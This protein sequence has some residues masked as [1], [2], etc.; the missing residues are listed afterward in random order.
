MAIILPE[1]TK[2]RFNTT[3]SKPISIVDTSNEA[4]PFATLTGDIAVKTG[5][6][7]IVNQHN[8]GLL[9]EV[10][11]VAGQLTDD[12]KLRLLGHDTADTYYC[13]PGEG[14]GSLCIASDWVNLDQVNEI[15]ASGG[16]PKFYNYTHLDDPTGRER[17]I[18]TGTSP[19][20]LTFKPHYDPNL[21][22]Y[23]AI[24]MVQF[25]RQAVVLQLKYPDRAVIYHY[26][27]L[28]MEGSPTMAIG[29]GMQV[30]VTFSTLCEPVLIPANKGT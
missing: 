10:V 4:P 27:H 13:E 8:W 5:D 3:Q 23:N 17:Q 1:G 14:K 6:V 7:L 11:A 28:S 25:H 30:S 26:G 2:V 18:P 22:W 15:S 19:V 21:P 9:K 29:Q 24:K 12:H 16:E 20:V